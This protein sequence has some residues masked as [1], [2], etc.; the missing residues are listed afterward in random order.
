MTTAKRPAGSGAACDSNGVVGPEEE[1]TTTS[2]HVGAAGLELP[3]T[4]EPLDGLQR[5]QV[6]LAVSRQNRK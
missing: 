4:T 3:E 1:L 5:E 6:D 2:G